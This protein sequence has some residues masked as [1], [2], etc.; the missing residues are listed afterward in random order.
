MTIKKQVVL[1]GAALGAYNEIRESFPFVSDSLLIRAALIV[2]S[3][4]NREKLHRA[5]IG[6]QSV[7]PGRPKVNGEAKK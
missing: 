5:C 4:V 1:A 7:G 3:E 6:A 2:A